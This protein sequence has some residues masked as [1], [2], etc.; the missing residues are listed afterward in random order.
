MLASCGWWWWLIIVV[1]YRRAHRW[2][3]GRWPQGV[4]GCCD[5]VLDTLT[6]QRADWCPGVVC[7]VG[8]VCWECRMYCS[9][10]GTAL[11][12]LSDECTLVTTAGCHSLQSA[13][14][15]TCLVRRSHNH[16]SD[17]CFATA[18]PMLWNSLPE[19]LR[20]PDIIFCQFKR[21]LKT[22]VSWAVAPCV[23]TLRALTRNLLT[24]FLIA[25]HDIIKC[26]VNWLS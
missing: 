7:Q 16:F 11:V 3:E 8:E 6:S 13:D 9:S 21:S 14:N 17:R 22:F 4:A 18:G 1:V 23:W 19:Q 15:L 26:S 5:A 24:Y 10:A 20:Q 12:Y 25:L 2:Q